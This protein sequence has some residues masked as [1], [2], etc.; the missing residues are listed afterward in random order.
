[1]EINRALVAA[2]NRAT[3]LA[4]KSWASIL[5]KDVD[6]NFN[7]LSGLISMSALI[8]SQGDLRCTELG[9]GSMEHGAG[10]RQV[11]GQ[12]AENRE[13]TAEV[14]GR[15]SEDSLAVGYQLLVI[16]LFVRHD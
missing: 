15:R 10:T 16:G 5:T 3:R 8:L 14:R 13:Q 7:T 9:A 1:L 12:R 6:P 4:S 11:R 2:F